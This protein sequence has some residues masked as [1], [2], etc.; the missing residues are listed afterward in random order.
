M[1]ISVEYLVLGSLVVSSVVVYDLIKV[2]K[3]LDELNEMVKM[4]LFGLDEVLDI[5]AELEDAKDQEDE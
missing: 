1:F 5:V 4:A 2:N 3:R